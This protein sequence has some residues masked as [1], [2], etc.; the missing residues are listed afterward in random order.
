MGK[1]DRDNLLSE[2]MDMLARYKKTPA[3]VRFVSVESIRWGKHEDLAQQVG[4]WAEFVAL[5]DFEYDGG[6]GGAEVAEALKVVG[7]DWWLERGEY[8]GSEWWEFK[9][10][11][12]RPQGTQ[13]LVTLHAGEYDE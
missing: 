12:E 9:Q 13:M 4:T 3:D 7:D 1:Q 5:A 6:Y 8:D 2:T 11:P 10:L